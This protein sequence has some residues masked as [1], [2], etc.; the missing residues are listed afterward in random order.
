MDNSTKLFSFSVLPFGLSTAPYVLTKCLRPLAQHWREKGIFMV[1]FLDNGWGRQSNASLCAKAA[2]TVKE[3]L[4][5]AGFVPNVEKS[6]L[7]PKQSLIW[8]GLSCDGEPYISPM[9]GLRVLNN[10]FLASWAISPYSLSQK[11]GKAYR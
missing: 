8:L 11:S 9:T 3:D 4:L 10:A 2:Q 5:A 7:A 6:N 1:L